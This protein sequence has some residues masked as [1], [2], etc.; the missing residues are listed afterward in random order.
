MSKYVD[1]FATSHI[2]MNTSFGK[3]LAHLI[4]VKKIRHVN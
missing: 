1:G 4:T 2:K 3:S